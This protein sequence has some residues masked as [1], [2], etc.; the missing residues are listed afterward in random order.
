MERIPYLRL[1]NITKTFPG[2][3]A[4]YS[5]NL[6]IEK[7]EVHAILGENG[8]GKSTLM[9]ILYGFYRP[10][11][12]NIYL[13]GTPVDIRSPLEASRLG[14]GMVFQNFMLIPAFSVVENIALALPKLNV[15]F[16]RSEM[17]E[18]MAVVADRYG[19]SVD[20]RARVWQLSVGEKQRVEIVKLLL[21]G[22]RMLIFDEPTSVLAPHEIEGLFQIF[23]NLTNDGYTILF[24]THKLR[25]VM[26]CADRV[27]VLRRGSVVGTVLRSDTTEQELAYMMLG[28]Q[29]LH[30]DRSTK[31][32][33]EGRSK[34]VLELKG[35]EVSDD[36]GGL[37][38]KEVSFSI[39]SGE[40]VG[41][42]GVSGNGQKELGEVVLG[43]RRCR[44]GSVLLHGNDATQWSVARILGEGVACMPEDPLVMGVAPGMTAQENMIL[45]DRMNYFRHGGL[46]IDWKAVRAEVERRVENFGLPIPNLDTPVIALSGGNVQRLVF[47]REVARRPSLLIA[48]YPTRGLDLAATKMANDL[49]LACREAGIAVLL[50][51]EDLEELFSLS[52]RLIVMHRGE[53]VGS[54]KPEETD[55]LEVGLLMTGSKAP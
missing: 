19:L 38:L 12:G 51:S 37:G 25:E 31:K 45:T 28:E 5:I 20:P 43:L 39:S 21:S 55:R 29:S 41:V 11:T 10:D 50:I 22:A 47:V 2:V 40:I 27:T 35:V 16:K 15:L 13:D 23:K 14:I 32:P 46:F 26:A 48:Y 52:D 18:R 30:L 34:T 33:P 3:L 49:L 6:S 7:S 4:N 9:K 53:V 44:A 8:A 36:R 1:E 17:E 24:I 54:F 42:A